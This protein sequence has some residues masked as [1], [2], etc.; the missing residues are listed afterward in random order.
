MA[1]LKEFYYKEVL[2]KLQK[3]FNY[4]N[5]ME[6]PR[7]K[8]IVMNIGVGEAITNPKFLDAAVEDL[9]I[10]SGQQPIVT[11]AKKSISNFKLRAG[12]PI[13]CA[14][15]LRR[16]R[17]YEFFDRLINIAIPRIRDFRGLPPKG[18]DGRGNY[19]LGLRE[20]LIFPEIDYD[21]IDKVR[22]LSVTFV[23]TSDDDEG[24][25]ALLREMGMPF[26]K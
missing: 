21:K 22:G 5:I 24:A 1:R 7:L 13:G 25:L 18:F 26:R 8:K 17:M 20:Q 14:V 2:P 3:E 19:T 10:I 6:V 23:T 16:E 4:K 15:T 9:R 12:M 11:R